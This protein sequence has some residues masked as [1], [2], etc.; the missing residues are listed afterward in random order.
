MLCGR[1]TPIKLAGQTFF[2]ALGESWKKKKL[3]PHF[4]STVFP[5]TMGDMRLG[6]VLRCAEQAR[7]MVG[8]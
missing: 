6:G 8:M 2:L 3:L 1:G 7:G 4:A 5:A